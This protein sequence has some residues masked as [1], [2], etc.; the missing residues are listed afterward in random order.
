M[1]IIKLAPKRKRGWTLPEM[2]VALGI[3]SI[4]GLALMGLWLFCIRG[5]ASLYNYSFLDQYNRQAMDVL[6]REIRESKLVLSYTTNSITI[7]AGNYPDGSPGPN[8]T[9]SFSPSTKKLIRTT[10]DGTSQV[11]LNSCSLLNFNLYQ[12]NVVPG[13]YD[14]Y[15]VA[16]N[17][18]SNTVKVIQ[19]TWKTSITSPTCVGNSEDVQT[20]RIVIRKQ[21]NDS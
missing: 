10:S 5:F 15:P 12:R 16:T 18:W 11:L 17:N 13:S 21:Q 1:C 4:C 19:L 3:F 9:Y 6:T 2:M 8:V 14:I 20:A 7:Q